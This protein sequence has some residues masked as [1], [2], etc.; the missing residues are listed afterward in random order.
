MKESLKQFLFSKHIL[1]ND[2]IEK[3][4][5]NFESLFSLANILNIK[6]TKGQELANLE[7]FK[8]ASEQ[9]GK[10]VPK[11][12]YVGFPDSVRNLSPD[13]LL[14]DQLVHY[15]ITY[16][17]GNFSE[18]GHSLFEE[19]FEKIAFKEKTPIKEFVI[20]NEQEAVLELENAMN[21]LLLSTRP[22][23]EVQYNLVKECIVEYDFKIEKC[24]C[25]NTT[26]KL[27]L[28]L[29][30]LN[31]A[32][33]LYLSEVITLVDY[34]NF[35]NYGNVKIKKL[36]LKN[37]DRKL[38]SKVID[39]TVENKGN[40]KDCYEKQAIWCGILHQIHYKPKTEK[41]IK[42]V[43]EMRSGV[44]KS[45]YSYFEQ[46]MNEQDYKKAIDVLVKQKGVSVLMRNLNYVLSRLE[47]NEDIEY[48]FEKLETKNNLIIIQN[49]LG[50]ANYKGAQARSFKFP[51]FNKLK[52]HNET[53]KEMAKRKSII[54]KGSCTKICKIL[55][56]NLANNLK[57]KLGKVFIDE[58]MENIALPIQ[59]TTAMGGFGTL[60]TGSR[61]TIDSTKKLRA[62]IYWEKVN[63]ID[64]SA[65]GLTKKLDQYEFSW[66]TMSG[67]QSNA[68]TFSGDITSGYKGASEYFDIDFDK[69]RKR[70]PKIE[71]LIVSANVYSW[72]PFKD[73]I[74]KAG[75]MARDIE[76]SGEIFEPK[77]VETS[78]TIN[79]DSTFAYMFAIDLKKNQVIW[80]NKARDSDLIVAGLSSFA[81]LKDYFTIT[82]II[83]VKKFFSLMATEIVDNIEEADI[84]IS[85]KT[86]ELKE[87]VEQIKSYDTD[88]MLKYLNNKD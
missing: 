75:F 68:L 51:K 42:F 84:V 8:F 38:I 81:V 85:D 52:V 7:I 41:A 76:H 46:A 33:L 24:A 19:Q 43:N 79:C 13:Q 56:R 64:L 11:P 25:K 83:N 28:D 67:Y 57:C 31:L 82:D 27:L 80:L 16:G 58:G 59:E 5:N 20:L 66:R 4:E 29:N 2:K 54:S 34:I 10:D 61:F 30:D 18:A 15:T 62:F 14:F 78:F 63:D 35:Y 12:F 37:Q 74:C 3:C 86:L 40:I 60:P 65:I 17:F 87:G 55:N 50:Y 73:C 88:K 53:N 45:P 21:N 77:T 6:I 23:S 39:I 49:L 36:N 1:V 9:I 44:N 32:K 47:N 22:L 48:L 26:I 72:T 70:F 69:F 71:Y